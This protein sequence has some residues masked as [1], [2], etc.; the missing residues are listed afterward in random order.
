M[1]ARARDDAGE[2]APSRR[3]VLGRLGRGGTALAGGLALTAAGAGGGAAAVRY[4][5]THLAPTARV[6]PR[7]E[8]PG[9]LSV[10][11]LFQADPAAGQVCL[12]FDDGPDPRWTPMVLDILASRG[13]PATF[14]VLG[15]A[16]AAHPEFVRSQVRA[17]HEVGVHSWTHTDVYSYP[18]GS[19][20]LGEVIDATIGAVTDAGAPAPRVWRPPYG[21][22]DAPALMVAAERGLDL[23]LWSHHTPS[24]AAAEAAGQAWAG[25]VILCHDARSQP[26]EELLA[27]VGTSIG[28]LLERGL[29]FVTASQMLAGA[30]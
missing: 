7:P 20:S 11:T 4:H 28:T 19:A 10:R 30:A 27:A 1:S 12:T 15:Q 29:T 17:G 24:V 16:A 5:D 21:R 23:V 25:S 6:A 14:F 22:V 18:K 3:L 26:S 2:Q 8:G 9:P 13:V